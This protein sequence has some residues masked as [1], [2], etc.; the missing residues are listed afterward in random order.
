MVANE[1][2]FADQRI[3]SIANALVIVGCLA[4]ESSFNFALRIVCTL[5]LVHIIVRTVKIS[6]AYFIRPF[7]KDLINNPVGNEWL[8]K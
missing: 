7:A 4:G 2:H 6:F 3:E 5:H 1:K 8:R